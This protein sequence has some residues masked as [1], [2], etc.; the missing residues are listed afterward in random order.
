MARVSVN[1]NGLSYEIA[2]EEG[3]QDSVLA[4]GQAVDD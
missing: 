2:C 1:I 4:L 3:Q